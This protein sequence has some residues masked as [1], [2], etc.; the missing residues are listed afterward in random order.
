[1]RGVF[2]SLLAR[3]LAIVL[4]FSARGEYCDVRVRAKHYTC[5][6]DVELDVVD[7]PH[8]TTP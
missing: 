4:P 2:V 8:H 7:A 6:N 1:M 5:T 3:K